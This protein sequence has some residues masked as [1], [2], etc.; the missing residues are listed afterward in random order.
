M[1]TFTPPTT[2]GLPTFD[3]SK[4]D[5]DG[6]HRLWSYFETWA[7]GKTVWRDQLGV[8]HEQTFPYQGGETHTVHDGDTTTVTTDTSVMSLANAQVVYHGGHV[9]TL[10]AQEEADLIAAGYGAFIEP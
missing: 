10:T 6:A 8:W 5:T 4:V 9:Y 3:P 1:P 2:D 7:M